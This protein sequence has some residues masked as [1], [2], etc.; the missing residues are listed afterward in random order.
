LRCFVGT[1]AER[2]KTIGLLPHAARDFY[3]RDPHRMPKQI[4]AR[5]FGIIDGRHW[6]QLGAVFDEGCI[7]ER[8]GFETIHGLASLRRFYELIRPIEQGQHFVETLIE[9]EDGVCASGRFEGVLRNGSP[10][11]LRFSDLYRLRGSKICQRTTF[12]FAPL[13]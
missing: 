13:V 3:E 11:Q 1:A 6:P 9:E 10:V 8:P 4:I 12:F 2:K 7:Y 5:M